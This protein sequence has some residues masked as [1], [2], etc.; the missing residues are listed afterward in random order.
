MDEGR[1]LFDD[2]GAARELG[3]ER[4]LTALELRACAA[5]EANE[6]VGVGAW[7]PLGGVSQSPDL[8]YVIGYSALIALELSSAKS[9]CVGS[10]GH[11]G[12]PSSAV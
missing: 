9:T 1:L 8:G 11:G 5:F 7:L 4:G 2:D 10:S 6:I 12:A 3:R